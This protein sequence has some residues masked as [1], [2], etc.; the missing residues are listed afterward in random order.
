MGFSLIERLADVQLKIV[1][2][3]SGNASVVDIVGGH[4]DAV[5]GT[6]PTVLTY[7]KAGTLRVLGTGGAK[8]S[9]LLPDVPTID[10]AG[11]PG[12]GLAQWWGI[13]APAGTPQPVVER[14]TSEFK[15]VLQ[16]QDL[17]NWFLNQGAELDYTGPTE[18]GE[19]I[20]QE[21]AKWKR[22]VKEAGIKLE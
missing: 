8:R 16:S 1:H 20:S 6:I 13:L 15:E 2:F 12:F 10:E 22:T 9:S 7:I 14:L 4:S 18:L 17:R 5:L 19:F 3:K 21:V 11:I